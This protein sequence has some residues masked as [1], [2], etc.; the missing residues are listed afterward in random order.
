[1]ADAE[2]K[3][4]FQMIQ[5]KKKLREEGL[6]AKRKE[7]TIDDG[8]KKAE[9]GE[10]Q[11]ELNHTRKKASIGLYGISRAIVYTI[12]Y[13]MRDELD[14]EGFASLRKVVGN[15]GFK[16]YYITKTDIEMI[17]AGKDVKEER[18]EFTRRMRMGKYT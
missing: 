12:R 6:D 15:I 5:A 3:R 16:G 13:K 18:Y 17:C 2:R 14:S 9:E 11:R 8:K 7:N 4:Q 10:E 1:M